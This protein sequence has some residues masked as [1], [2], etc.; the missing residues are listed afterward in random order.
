MVG[1]EEAVLEESLTRRIGDAVVFING[2]S[3]ASFFVSGGKRFF[4]LSK[5]V[6]STLK[7]CLWD[8]SIICT[9]DG[10]DIVFLRVDDDSVFV[11]FERVAIT[12]FE[13]YYLDEFIVLNSKIALLPEGDVVCILDLRSQRVIKELT[14]TTIAA[15]CDGM[16]VLKQGEDFF[17]L[18]TDYNLIPIEVNGVTKI[19]PVMGTA[20]PTALVLNQEEIL[21][22]KIE[23]NNTMVLEQSGFSSLKFRDGFEPKI[24]FV[25]D[26]SF[27]FVSDRGYCCRFVDNDAQFSIATCRLSCVFN[28]EGVLFFHV[29]S[30][31]CEL[32]IEESPG[33]ALAVTPGSSFALF[34]ANRYPVPCIQ[35][36]GHIFAL[37]LLDE[38]PSAVLFKQMDGAP[39]I[40]RLQLFRE[41][42][43][44]SMLYMLKHGENFTVYEGEEELF[45]VTE[46]KYPGIMGRKVFNREILALIAPVE[47]VTIGDF[48]KEFTNV[49]AGM[50]GNISWHGDHIWMSGNGYVISLK[51]ENNHV[52]SCTEFFADIGT[53]TSHVVNPHNPKMAVVVVDEEFEVFIENEGV[54]TRIPL[55]MSDLWVCEHV[56]VAKSV[57]FIGDEL[58]KIR[59]GSITRLDVSLSSM[60]GCSNP[61]SCFSPKPGVLKRIIDHRMHG[62]D[63]VLEVYSFS[64]DFKSVSVTLER[65][66]VVAL[67]EKA[68]ITEF[69][70]EYEPYY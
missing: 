13:E 54:F 69:S 34:D 47:T 57:L 44:F 46:D 31:I 36:N 23:E 4:S 43:N 10:E 64:R 27:Y 11:E 39:G 40:D 6:K 53:H 56:F 45:S 18:D 14:E 3:K 22:L 7:R 25:R 8:Q 30:K 19:I 33:A 68:K 2:E 59:N 29:N 16:V 52:V 65:H 61:T 38:T 20:V 37:N 62:M 41:G 28:I 49:D 26:G 63:I 9:V 58:F 21:L 12:D 35:S 67:A 17:M 66:D 1:V 70:G 51:I 60:I 55:T 50:P 5:V 48:V 32:I 42:C 15:T 24:S